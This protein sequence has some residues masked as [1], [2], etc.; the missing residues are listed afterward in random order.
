MKQEFKPEDIP[1]WDGDGKT[2]LKWFADCQ[3]LAST[4]GYLPDQMGRYMYLRLKADSPV[5]NW[6]LMQTP[7]VKEIMRAHY[8]NFLE[9]VKIN[10]LGE[11]WQH[12]R[13]MEYKAQTFRQSGHRHEAPIDFVQ[14]RLL[15][16]RMLV[17]VPIGGRLEV[18]ELI[19]NFPIAWKTILVTKTINATEE[20]VTR[21]R[22]HSDQLELA[23]RTSTATVLTRENASG[24]IKDIVAEL[25]RKRTVDEPKRTFFRPRQVQFTSNRASEDDDLVRAAFED[26]TLS[27]SQQTFAAPGHEERASPVQAA[28]E[29][30]EHVSVREIFAITKKRQRKPPVGGYPFPIRNGVKSELRPPPSPCKCCGSANHWD[31]ECPWYNI[32]EKKFGKKKVANMVQSDET[33]N[34]VEDV[35]NQ[36]YEAL[37]IHAAYSQYLEPSVKKPGYLRDQELRK[38]GLCYESALEQTAEPFPRLTRPRASVEEVPDEGDGHP[39]NVAAARYVLEDPLEDEEQG[40]VTEHDTDPYERKPK[41]SQSFASED[42]VRWLPPRRSFKPG[43]SAV[44]QSVVAIK[45]RVSDRGEPEIDLRLDSCADIS[46]ISEEM[47]LRLRNPP[48]L[49]KGLKFSLW[50]LTNK[51]CSMKGYVKLPIFVTTEAGET[52]GMEAEAYVVPGM[53]VPILLGEDFQN[54]YEL[55]VS[56]S[57]AFGTTIHFGTSGLSSNATGVRRTGD[58]TLIRKSAQTIQAHFVKAKTHRRDKAKRR[59]KLLALKRDRELVRAAEDIRIPAHTCRSVSVYGDFGEEKEWLVETSL[60]QSDTNHHLAVPNTLISSSNPTIP[61]ANVSNRPLVVHKGD[62]LGRLS[63]PSRELDLPKTEE[64]YRAMESTAHRISALISTAHV[65]GIIHHL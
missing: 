65:A 20:L 39:K 10:F 30:D 5:R 14:R 33:D 62:V 24:F 32:W 41:G 63:D 46:L 36:A 61:V 28:N 4:G 51:D 50:Q 25:T 19:K 34:Q 13:N 6:F 60:L 57:V 45:G 42:K 26:A 55:S 48:K 44:G 21:V 23:F 11:Q 18:L 17:H 15:Y 38:A 22:D 40:T 7:Q 8:L 16:C 35:Y 2:A 53:T 52:I 3:E 59:R 49:R 1:E 47:Y 64:S 54:T 37:I 58:H 27:E 9:Y 12:E 31:K 56:R 29:T 43:F